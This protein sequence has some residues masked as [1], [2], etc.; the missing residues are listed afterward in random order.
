MSLLVKPAPTLKFVEICGAN[1]QPGGSPDVWEDLDVSA[2]V[3]EG[4]AAVLVAMKHG[5]VADSM[6][7]TRKKGSSYERDKMIA[8]SA[9]Y[10]QI[11]ELDASRVLQ[12]SA[13][14]P[15]TAVFWLLGYWV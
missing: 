7:G 14:D 1:H 3:P 8:P 15:S 12:I 6:I 9:F 10:T 2:E 4:A 5:D 11:T 13:H